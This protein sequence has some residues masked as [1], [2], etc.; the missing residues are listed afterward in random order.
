MWVWDYKKCSLILYLGSISAPKRSSP[1]DSKRDLTKFLCSCE[2]TELRS[3]PKVFYTSFCLHQRVRKTQ[4][5]K[6]KILQ[7]LV[8]GQ[9]ILILLYPSKQSAV[10]CV[11]KM[12]H[13]MNSAD[14]VSV[15]LLRLSCIR[16]YPD[17]QAQDNMNFQ[18][19]F[20]FLVHKLITICS[21]AWTTSN[22]EQSTKEAKKA[23]WSMKFWHWFFWSGIA[24]VI[25][26]LNGK[27][28][29][30]GL[31]SRQGHCWWLC[32]LKSLFMQEIVQTVLK[33][34]L[35]NGNGHQLK[36]ATG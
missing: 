28:R 33:C 12:L 5:G 7:T 34:G 29:K 16:Q 22:I 9:V 10:F 25:S 18:A 4:S 11:G 32:D 26:C 2:A 13:H 24:S 36:S 14:W 21:Q 19:D 30:W 6:L 8:F 3:G 35:P 23:K 20:L 17:Y 27:K 31:I 15:C 1:V